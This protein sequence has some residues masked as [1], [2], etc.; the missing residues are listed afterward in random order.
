MTD[1]WKKIKHFKKEEFSCRCGCGLNI[2]NKD[3]VKKLDKARDLA[4][5]S[6]FI[7][8]AC[9]CISHN[10]SIKGSITSSHLDGLAVDIDIESSSKRYKVL[11]SLFAVGF[12]RIG[13]YSDFVHADID[14]EKPKNMIWYK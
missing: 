8:S 12:S 1:F 13:I 10:N 3:L 14:I 6:F 9:R 4:N 11:Y 5:T 2:I 7:T